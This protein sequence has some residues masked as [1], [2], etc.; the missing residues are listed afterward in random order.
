MILYSETPE[1]HRK[2][3]LLAALAVEI[4][5][6]TDGRVMADAV[7]A[8]S[9]LFA[10]EQEAIAAMI[11]GDVQ[12][13]WPTVGRLEQYAPEFGLLTLPYSVETLS[14]R[15]DEA[16]TELSAALTALLKDSDIAV[17]GLAPSS[18]TLIV[19]KSPI[20]SAQD[21]AGK[22]VRVPG[23]PMLLD[24]VSELGATGVNLPAPDLPTMMAEERVD[25]VMTSF[26]G[27]K[28]L[29]PE[30]G[31]YVLMDPGMRIGLYGIIVNK[32]WL[33]SLDAD[34]R[35]AISSATKKT[36]AL[37]WSELA[38]EMAAIKEAMA[39]A[40]TTLTEITEENAAPFKS[41]ADTVRNKYVSQSPD[42]A[43]EFFQ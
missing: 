43:A 23:S 4:R 14:L 41:A 16:Q 25:V 11:E 38:E 28:I 20:S 12:M 21:L 9:G 6:L 42:F 24:Y 15:D 5:E 27:W 17:L 1:T 18:H 26:G 37:R 39:A 36:I 40:G 2:S 34:D 33:D 13:I 29:G 22:T 35:A 3:E 19:S 32:S 30:N 31:R 10:G 8:E 7:S